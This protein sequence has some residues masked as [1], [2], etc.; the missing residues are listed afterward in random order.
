MATRRKK[1]TAEPLLVEARE[2]FEEI[3]SHEQDQRDRWAD[4]LR[5]V[6]GYQWPDDMLRFR[7]STADGGAPRPC[8]V[9]D[10]TN[11]YRRQV[12]NDAR[13]NPPSLMARPR[14][15][16]GSV[17]VADDL[18]RSFRYIEEASRA[19]EAYL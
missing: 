13:L 17:E 7:Q 19:Q 4:D 15:E 11:Q 14:D 3:E 5:F 6:A 8:L 10:Q 16:K 18:H 2:V 12:I 9:V 1:A